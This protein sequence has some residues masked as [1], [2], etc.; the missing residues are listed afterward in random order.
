M[1][2]FNILHGWL[3]KSVEHYVFLENFPKNIFSQN[4]RHARNLE[5]YY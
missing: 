2:Y 3:V 4:A 1:A 5:K